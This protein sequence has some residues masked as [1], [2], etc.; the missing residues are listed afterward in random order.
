[1]SPSPSGDPAAGAFLLVEKDGLLGVI[2]TCDGDGR[3]IAVMSPPFPDRVRL[4]AWDGAAWTLGSWADYEEL[5]TQQQV[6]TAARPG[7][8]LVTS[9]DAHGMVSIVSQQGWDIS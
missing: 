7:S 8:L 1:V 5:R 4:A 9:E 6:M 2:I 3:G